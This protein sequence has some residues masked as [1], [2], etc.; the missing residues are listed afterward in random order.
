MQGGFL[1]VKKVPAHSAGTFTYIDF[2]L[3]LFY[4]K[5]KEKAFPYAV[6]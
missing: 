6:G 2:S 4:T 1:S 5:Y 3:N